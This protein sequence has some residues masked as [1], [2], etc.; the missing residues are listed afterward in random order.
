[1]VQ[2]LL[3]NHAI[4]KKK[5]MNINKP[6]SE[7]NTHFSGLQIRCVV[8]GFSLF[9]YDFLLPRFFFI[10][11]MPL[12]L[13]LCNTLMWICAAGSTDLSFS[14]IYRLILIGHEALVF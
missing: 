12:A 14:N 13:S 3:I 10:I 2:H 11:V 1:M 9:E 4:N 5:V 7:F 6:D 8:V